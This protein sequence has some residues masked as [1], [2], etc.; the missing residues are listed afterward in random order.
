MEVIIAAVESLCG[1]LARKVRERNQA[2]AL[3]RPGLP[4]GAELNHRQRADLL[5]LVELALLIK[6]TRGK[7]FVFTAVPDLAQRLER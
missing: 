7:G 5:G 2:E 3:L 4:L 6:D 1:Y